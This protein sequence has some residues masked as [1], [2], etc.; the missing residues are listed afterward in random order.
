MSQEHR[1]SI[2]TETRSS[3]LEIVEFS[4]KDSVYGINIAKVRE[5]INADIDLVPTP[6]A[7]P[8]I[9]GAINLRGAIIP[10]VN[11]AKHLKVNVEADPKTNRI[12]IAE[13]NKIIV[14]FLVS[15]VARIHRLSWKAVEAPSDMMTTDQS[16]ASGIVKIQN[17]VIFLLD[18][19][20]IAYHIN[21][22][23]HIQAPTAGQYNAASFD[24]STKKIL[25]VDDSDLSRRL[26]L[27]H[28]KQAGYQTDTAIHGEDAWN[29]LSS[30][31]SQPGFER[32]ETS[33]N[34]MVTDIE[35]PQLDGLHLIKRIKEEARLRRLPCIAFSSI[36][37]K[38]TIQ[39]ARNA[40]A[41]GEI[42]K[43]EISELVNLVDAKVL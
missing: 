9:H 8:S 31:L 28:L 3:E 14:G 36:I 4:I 39:Q 1:S 32:I 17:K 13:F 40:G 16:Y 7:H 35:M 18:F 21:P 37:S 19:E 20:K 30:L 10:V 26:I 11:L 33:Y 41:D 24:R 42:S 43:P 38:E 23:A 27:D 2:V 29:K 34:L 12:I 5:I 6:D 15:S 25:I 22:R